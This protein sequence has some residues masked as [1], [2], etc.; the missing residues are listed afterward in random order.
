MKDAH[1]SRQ[2]RPN[3][4]WRHILTRS[5][6]AA[7]V[8]IAGA[9]AALADHEGLPFTEPFDDAHLSD[10]ASTTADWGAT[11][12]GFLT[13]PSAEPL[14]DVFDSTASGENVGATEH[15]TRDLVLAD[16]NGDGLLD[17]VEAALGQNGIYLNQG[18]SFPAR[19][20]LTNDGGNSRGAAVGDFDRDGALDVVVGNRNVP[21]R[22]YLNS[23]DGVQFT[24]FDISPTVVETDA[25]DVADFN[26][27]GW[28][29]VVVANHEFSNNLIYYHT[30]NPAAPFG[31]EGV[32]GI[33]IGDDRLM[34]S[35]DVAVGDLDNDGDVDIV[36]FNE[37]QE[38]FAF[39]NDGAG[40][41]TAVQVGA[42]AD[43][44]QAGTLGDLN[45]DGFLDVV[46]GNYEI[47]K[48]YLSSGDP[49]AL[50]SEVSPAFELSVPDNPSFAHHV[51]VADVDNDGDL[52]IL[53]GTAGLQAEAPGT[54]YFNWLF[55][56]DGQ[57]V[58]GAGVPIGADLDVTNALAIGDV[59][60]D[61][62]LD[63]IAGNENRDDLDTALPRFNRL[64][65]NVGVPSGDEP[66]V[67]L[68][69]A[70]TSLRVDTETDP[71]DAV[72]LDAVFETLGT[73]VEAEFWVSSNGGATWSHIVPGAGPLA[74]PEGI[75]GAD[76]R[77]RVVLDAL[78]PADAAA[79]ALDS[80]TITTSSP[81]FTSEPVTEAV[82]D[83]PYSYEVV[84]ADPNEGET[85]TLTAVTVPAWLTFTD[86]GDGTG[87]LAGTP[88]ADDVGAHDVVLE[89]SDDAGNTSRQAFTIEVAA[90]EPENQPPEF[91]SAPTTEAEAGSA[92]TYAV[93][94]SDP[95]GD[96]VT[97][98]ASSIP[99][100]LTLT[101]N[102]DGTAT[103]AGTPAAGDVGEHDVVLQAA[104][105]DGETAE[106]TFT[107]TVEA[108]PSP[109][110]SPPTQPPPTTSP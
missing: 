106:Q 42:E 109:P 49:A 55:I 88:T 39:L 14:I 73:N 29:D 11:R 7:L 41:F 104:D 18:G 53:I 57:G 38:N 110:S 35:Q 61:G 24:G 1:A 25:I 98:T 99:A 77:W 107:I 92:Y 66:V 32:E 4:E 83:A 103:L 101:D 36:V 28:L 13:M 108:A 81:F 30:G 68:V 90:P 51:D 5:V 19:I 52:D 46:V 43:N 84:A 6:T 44:S 40:N 100:W 22:L 105:E 70:A 96:P 94:V 71:I 69:A 16:L 50:F 80:V 95:D 65:R 63:V 34:H 85:L 45:G 12:P 20:N 97:I 82:V 102:G 2:L 8:G 17:L 91:T 64:Y 86:N 67:Q 48:V 47:S 60:G 74:F 15:I 89:V 93:A 10:A 62:R 75:R 3:A 56:N 21:S 72:S 58:F 9:Q 26:G 76:L 33:P 23:G 78:S 87:A 31:T 59:D 54:R 27:D 79:L 37:L